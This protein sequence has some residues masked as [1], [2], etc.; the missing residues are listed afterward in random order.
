M[1]VYCNLIERELSVRWCCEAGVDEALL[2]VVVGALELTEVEWE[3]ARDGAVEASLHERR[4][5]LLQQ[6]VASCVR[7]EHQSVVTLQRYGLCKT[8]RQQGCVQE[9]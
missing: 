2:L 1:V 8:F 6:D 7:L 9:G 4:P 3:A 5:V